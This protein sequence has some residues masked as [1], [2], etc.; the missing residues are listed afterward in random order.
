MNRRAPDPKLRRRA[1][2]APFVAAALTALALWPGAPTASAQLAPE[3]S[4]DEV[5]ARFARPGYTVSEPGSS[6]DGVQ[7]FGVSTTA[8]E[9]PGWPTLRVLVFADSETAAAHRHARGPRLL[10][11]YGASTL[12]G[13]VALVQ[14]S[15]EPAAFPA[16]PECVPDPVFTDL[17]PQ[18]AVSAPTSGVDAQFI[19]MLSS[20]S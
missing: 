14:L 15:Q 8:D 1:A 9:Q 6:S 19:E 18:P 13:N 12:I 2:R 4:A 3:L 5:R 17:A 11:G 16:E 7:S 20:A 10:S